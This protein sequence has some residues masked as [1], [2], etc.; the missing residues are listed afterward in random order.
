MGL[1]EYAV[2]Y[3]AGHATGSKA[4]GNDYGDIVKALDEIRRS[5]ETKAALGVVAHHL[6]V[7]LQEAGDVLTGGKPGQL[8][9]IDDLVEFARTLAGRREALLGPF[10]DRGPG[11]RSVE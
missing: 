7:T 11:L 2:V 10:T 5:P 1:L 3:L 8:P 6:G 9:G 4:R